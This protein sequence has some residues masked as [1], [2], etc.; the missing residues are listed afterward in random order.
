VLFLLSLSSAVFG[1]EIL[2]IRQFGTLQWDHATDV[3]VDQTGNVY[4]VGSTYGVL[5]DQ[6][7][8]GARDAFVRKYNSSGNEL[9]TRQ[10]GATWDGGCLALAVAVDTAGNVYVAGTVIGA[11]PE[12]TSAGNWDAFLRKYDA[13]GN[14]VWTRQF[15][16]DSSDS[17]N[18]V[19]VDGVGNVYVIGQSGQEAYIR[20][21]DSAGN[22]LWTRQF[23]TAAGWAEAYGV[24][25]DQAGNVYVI[26]R[27]S[28]S[29]PLNFG[30]F[31]RKYDS[32]GNELWTREF[33]TAAG[34][35]IYS[36]ATDEAGNLYIAGYTPQAL[37]GQT[38][39]GE[40][41]AFVGKFNSAGD[42][43]WVRQ[44]GTGYCDYAWGVV[45][46][47]ISNIYV[48]GST[49][50]TLPGQTGAGIP[51]YDLD[52]YVRKY[53]GAGNEIW[54][55]QFG[56]TENDDARGI[57][58]DNAGNVY[59]CGWTTGA[60]PEQSNNGWGDAFVAKI[61]Q[62]VLPGQGYI[63][64]EVRDASTSKGIQGA[65]VEA[66]GP[67]TSSTTTDSNGNY[68]LTLPPGTYTLTAKAS[69]YQSQTK[70]GV[71][72][73]ADQT[74]PVDFSL[75]PL[76]QKQAPIARASD[77]SD[78]PKTLYAEG[79][80]TLTA[81]YFDPD[82]RSDLK[83]CYLRLKH[84]Q[85]PLTMM[86]EE[87][88]GQ[89]W[90]W[91]GEEGANY[92]DNVKAS[93]EP[94]VDPK[95]GFEGYAITWVFAVKETWPEVDSGV[96]FGVYATDEAGNSSGWSYVGAD[97]AFVLLR[98]GAGDRPPEA[99]IRDYPKAARNLFENVVLQLFSL[100]LCSVYKVGDVIVF[101]ASSS[102]DDSGMI[103]SY[104]WDFGDN[105]G[106]SGKIVEHSYQ[107]QG[108]YN[109]TLLVR[110]GQGL[111]DTASKFVLIVSPLTTSAA[112]NELYSAMDALGG[113]TTFGLV[114]P[115]AIENL[116]YAGYKFSAE[117]RRG[118]QYEALFSLLLSFFGIEKGQPPTT[119][120]KKLI[121]ILAKAANIAA[122]EE[123]AEQITEEIFVDIM[124]KI[125]NDPKS[126]EN[127]AN[128]VLN[129]INNYINSVAQKVEEIK[130]SKGVET[131]DA[132]TV[133]A[134]SEDLTKRR[135]GNAYL[136]FALDTI[137]S[138][139]KQFA[140]L[141]VKD[142]SSFIALL[143]DV[144]FDVVFL[145][146]S[147]LTS[148]LIELLGGT[149]SA[150]KALAEAFVWDRYTAIALLLLKLADQWLEWI[151]SNTLQG[152]ERLENV[153][154]GQAPPRIDGE[155]L[156]ISNAGNKYRIRVRNTGDITT[157][158]YLFI[159]REHKF[160]SY[161]I[162]GKLGSYYPMPWVDIYSQTLAPDEEWTLE[163]PIPSYC[164]SLNVRLL[165]EGNNGGI[166]G[167][168]EESLNLANGSLI[169]AVKA[170][171][172]LW[173]E[174]PV[175]AIVKD[176]QGRITG[177]SQG[178]I[179]QQIPNSYYDPEGHVILV[180]DPTADIREVTVVGTG[181]GTYN[182][183]MRKG[184]IAGEIP[185]TVLELPITNGEEHRYTI[186]W[187]AVAQGENGTT[188]EIDKNKDGQPEEV[189]KFQDKLEGKGVG[190]IFFKDFTDLQ[191]WTKT[192]LWHLQDTA[193]FECDLMEGAFA[194]Y[195][196]P[197][198]CTY[199]VKDKRGR[200][201]R[202][203]GTLTSPIITI[204]KNTALTLQFD[205]F[206]EV[207]RY[208]RSTLDRTYVQIRLGTSGKTVRW[209]SWKTIWSRSS[210]DPSPECNTASY[211]FQSKN[212]DRLQIR[213]IFD[214]VNG[215]NN[216][217]R[218]WAID[219]LVVKPAPTP[220]KALE[221][222][223]LGLGWD[224]PEDFEPGEMKVLNI[225]NP[226][227]DVHTTV[228][229]VLGVEAEGIKVE[230]YDLTGRLVWKGEAEGN[231]LPWD[232]RDLTGLPL[233]NGVYLYLVYVKVEGEWIVSDV[234]KLVILR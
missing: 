155:I 100:G 9:W 227:R 151:Q 115:Q 73:V 96:D 230:V 40:L 204:P 70:T 205:F 54:T 154:R 14:A 47:T 218:G 191:G 24:A 144:F 105:T 94:I 106:A 103:T 87:A 25:V 43:L 15:G 45:V 131:L 120:F 234:Q 76:G 156:N 145:S 62:G 215:N 1:Q 168:D 160:T 3:A 170:W 163:I 29:E 150:T 212:Y 153:A 158:F 195:A 176:S 162:A 211:T 164:T 31:I 42:E 221:V 72:V 65:T 50:G 148:G 67:I 58:V 34:A 133:L 63:A 208:T 129:D 82:G 139:L 118:A 85:K 55:R 110:D 66:S 18:D 127:Y 224:V 213:F 95:T 123:V 219:N 197:D 102:W 11:L 189:I 186:D 130:S 56:S 138:T 202:T 161:E 233:A 229:T 187:D 60:L 179:Y 93:A 44:F 116:A 68:T 113:R 39:M 152:L 207:E 188:L 69:G 16:T 228:F 196:Q 222:T 71:E 97:L 184:N 41:D 59:I 2:W 36:V 181:L 75:T 121:K 84:P 169:R 216:N 89:V 193:C 13:A 165:A 23:T 199:E 178:Q 137:A 79:L 46:D 183:H 92:L 30:G 20:K 99:I 101:D 26:G 61:S 88:S 33:G 49:Y 53:D 147:A 180:L 109:V 57:A 98:L 214:S 143:G 5:P 231:E 48:A 107:N 80:Y 173:W 124:G 27:P 141:A 200:S 125:G 122:I 128:N 19:A 166:Y 157:L 225:P 203:S 172:S 132:S 38:S 64:G 201:V 182:L 226:V 104:S 171:L 134:L 142:S 220:T 190:A 117:L 136:A 140:E 10:F 86:W 28:G 185:I 8:V 209:G 37:P 135:L 111:S 78:V 17:A 223:D 159:T 12:Q 146:A 167:L 119:E 177:V 198:S 52:I 51:G 90:T 175:E 206:R 77:I 108:I 35:E 194:Y 4:V 91:A 174:S 149:A 7:K 6:T 74:T 81:K 112:L 21:Y 217:Y 22:E 83:Y 232:T 210:K 114:L 126:F 32:A 192:G